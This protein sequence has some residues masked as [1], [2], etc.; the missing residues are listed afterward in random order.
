[1]QNTEDTSKSTTKLSIFTNISEQNLLLAAS[2]IY[3]QKV[4]TLSHTRTQKKKGIRH[5]RFLT[6]LK[7]EEKKRKRNRYS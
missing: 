5:K 4:F 7:E 1:M 2:P 6:V 3:I